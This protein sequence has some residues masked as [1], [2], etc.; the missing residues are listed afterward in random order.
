MTWMPST[1]RSWRSPLR[2]VATRTISLVSAPAPA[3]MI[4]V[5]PSWLM[6][7]PGIG[8]ITS[9][10]RGSASSIRVTWART[11]APRPSVT[12]PSVECTTT[13]MAEEALPPKLSWASSRAATDSEP[14]A[15]QPAPDRLCS[16][17]GAKAPRPTMSSSQTPVTSLAWLVT[18]RPRRPRG[19]GRK[20]GVKS[21]E[22][23]FDGAVVVLM[24]VPFGEGERW[25]VI[26]E[27]RGPRG[28][29]CRRRPRGPGR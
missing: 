26:R 23:R 14:S 21:A 18:Q 27:G 25:V 13:W 28:R 9:A 8:W 22:A 4:A 1:E 19:P 12:G 3:R 5:L 10:M 6:V 7:A 15:C 2:S 29:P 24:D 20:P 11:S 17:W 16:T